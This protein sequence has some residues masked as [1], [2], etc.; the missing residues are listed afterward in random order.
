ITASVHHDERPLAGAL[1]HLKLHIHLA[2]DELLVRAWRDGIGILGDFRHAADEE[3]AL[4]ADLQRPGQVPLVRRVYLGSR[5]GRRSK[6]NGKHDWRY[7]PTWGR[8]PFAHGSS[9]LA[10]TR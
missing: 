4:V 5:S 9:P 2:D 1:G 3:A 8:G 10:R 7:D 6:R